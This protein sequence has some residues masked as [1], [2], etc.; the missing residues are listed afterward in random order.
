MSGMVSIGLMEGL[1]ASLAG[2]VAGQPGLHALYL[3]LT[4]AVPL[5]MAV[6]LAISGK[7]PDT[8]VR[9]AGVFGFLVPGLL[10]V[11]LTAAYLAAFPA[12]GYGFE[13]RSDLGLG[14]FGIFFHLGL[15]GISVPFFLLSGIVGTAAGL[16]AVQVETE[17]RRILLI[18]LLVMQG[19]LMGVFASVDVLFFYLFHEFALIP[20]FVLIA[21]MGRRGRKTVALELTIYL[22]LGAMLSLGGLLAIYV[23]SGVET[24]NMVALREALGTMPHQGV[25]FGLLLIGFGIL[26]SLFPF[27]S[28]APRGYATAPAPV[29]M[30]H[31]G[32]LKKFGLYGLIQIAFPLLP[33]GTA[34]WAP[35]MM[36]L[37]LGNLILIGMV[38][39]AQRDLKMML[40][41]ASVMHMGYAFLGLFAYSTLG[42][43]AAIL[44]LFAHGLSV[45]LL[46]LLADVV[47]RRGG[48]SDMDELG[49]LGGKAPVLMGLFVAATMASIGLPGFA[50]F[51]GELGIF[52][53]LWS[54][55][56]PWVLFPAVAGILL[57]AI[58]GLRSVAAIF[59]GA[60][61]E[62]LEVKGD[63]RSSEKLPAVLLLV[64]LLVFGLW[65]RVLTDPVNES[66]QRGFAEQ[67][68]V[69][70]A[71]LA[72]DTLSRKD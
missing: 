7:L 61:P 11:Y 66:L 17:Q 16:Y 28:W 5:T 63:I 30:L 14:D 45:A 53:A 67:M 65:P 10:S 60:V 9:L 24:F 41:N 51:W 55:A 22:T 57:S 72:K 29:A 46:F 25:I 12:G 49:G 27:H 32:V 23:F 35:L 40:G 47:E 58:Y 39:I 38:T 36:W 4:V 68:P 62:G 19:G 21:L 8:A 34:A 37:A 50:N 15:N 56:S 18:L 1:S 69:V 70:E 44:M 48:T 52:V 2:M 54:S 31:A 59:F 33:E 42:V 71:P 13:L 43:G 6:A 3:L 26:V 64:A 20:T